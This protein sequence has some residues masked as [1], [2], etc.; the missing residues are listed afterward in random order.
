MDTRFFRFS[1]VL[2]TVGDS[3]VGGDC[4]EAIFQAA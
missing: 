2:D 4:H 1:N 3:L